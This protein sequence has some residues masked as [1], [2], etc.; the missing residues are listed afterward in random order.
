MK[1]LSAARKGTV[2]PGLDVPFVPGI[3]RERPRQEFP[4][5]NIARQGKERARAAGERTTGLSAPGLC[6]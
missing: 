3:F 4:R 1:I 6:P 5:R 2:R